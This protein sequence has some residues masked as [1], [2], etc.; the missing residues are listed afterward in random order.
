MPRLPI[1]Y[2]NAVIYKLSCKD[3]NIT[4]L[5]IGS[6]TNFTVR[7][8]QLKLACNNI[9]NVK[10]NCK[11]YQFFRQNGGWE[12]W[13]MIEIEKFAC[14]SKRELEKREEELRCKFEA[15]LNVIA[16]WTDKKKCIIN[17]CNN[18][19]HSFHGIWCKKHIRCTWKLLSDCI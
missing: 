2:S 19:R 12:N 1:D 4:E 14:N 5:Y 8:N 10:N 9:K 6:T 13:E 15:K 16:C 17:G 7:K 18:V 3:K 11:K